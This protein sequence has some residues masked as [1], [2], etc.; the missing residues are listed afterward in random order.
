VGGPREKGS[1]S[2]GGLAVSAA[3]A[4]IAGIASSIVIGAHVVA[5]LGDGIGIAVGYLAA[6]AACLAIP[7]VIGARVAGSEPKVPIVTGAIA[8]FSMIW[9]A[10]LIGLAPVASRAVLSEHGD[11]FLPGDRTGPR[12]VR[13]V[14]RAIAQWIPGSGPADP[15][16]RDI[17]EVDAGSAAETDAVPSITGAHDAGLGASAD[18]QQ[19]VAPVAGERG[20]EPEGPWRARELF[21]HR[22]DAV[23]TIQVRRRIDPDDPLA[24]LLQELGMGESVEVSGSGI[25]LSSDGTIVTNHHVMDDA[26]TA[27]VTLRGGRSFDVVSVLSVDPSNDLEVIA[28][29]AA[30]LV[31]AP[32]APEGEPDVGASVFA[33]GSPLGLDHTLTEGIVSAI[34]EQDGTTLVQMQA[35]IA[36]GSSG[37]PLFDD[38]GRVVGINTAMRAAGMNFAVSARHVRALLEGPRA[39]RQLPRHVVGVHATS[40]VVTGAPLLPTTRMG[41]EQLAVLTARVAASCIETWP[42]TTPRLTLAINRPTRRR[43]AE[44]EDGPSLRSDQGAAVDRCVRERGDFAMWSGVGFLREASRDP[45]TVTARVEG[46]GADGSRT[47]TVE[48][49]VAS[50][51]SSSR[52]PSPSP[53]P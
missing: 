23:V 36:P 12:P 41:M 53:A 6:A 30:D 32:L 47:M 16:A 44:E 34:R 45:F 4:G 2:R 20:A 17:V 1:R 42:A 3:V 8:T 37:G 15:L 25:V 46:L 39:A 18:P 48:L 33:I 43:S 29:E 7:A 38:R 31:H 5:Q 22:A 19:H 9:L 10:L 27:R 28:V 40:L 21:T 13:R 35:P 14:I 51:R 24:D 11:W 50:S 49:S 52:S 26:E